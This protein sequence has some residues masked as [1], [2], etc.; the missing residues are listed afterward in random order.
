MIQNQCPTQTILL[1]KITVAQNEVELSN[2]RVRGLYL[3]AVVF[4]ATISIYIY[5]SLRF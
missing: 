1:T 4:V 2:H 5:I 3:L